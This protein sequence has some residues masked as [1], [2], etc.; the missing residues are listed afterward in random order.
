MILGP[1]AWRLSMMRELLQDTGD[2]KPEW[3]S[4]IGNEMWSFN[5]PNITTFNALGQ[6]LPK[7]FFSRARD[8]VRQD[9]VLQSLGLR[10]EQQV[11][12]ISFGERQGVLDRKDWI[13]HHMFSGARQFLP[14]DPNSIDP[15]DLA[16]Y[17]PYFFMSTLVSQNLTEAIFV[18]ED[19]TPVYKFRE[20][21]AVFHEQLLRELPDYDIV[22]LGTCLGIQDQLRYKNVTLFHSP[23]IVMVPETRCFN[24]VMMSN[25]GARAVLD[26]GAKRWSFE[27]IDLLFNHLI[28]VLGLKCAWAMPPLFFEASKSP[29]HVACP[30]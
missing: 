8:S 4:D 9:R 3:N 17:A 7:F 1:E 23:N 19:A 27:N 10:N 5:Y 30:H 12:R 24:A 2:W 22:I 26:G 6:V 20:K 18:E 14:Q 15:H 25:K 29:L 11:E 16:T 28:K 13:V 21:F